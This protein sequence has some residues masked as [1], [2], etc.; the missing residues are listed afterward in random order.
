VESAY[1]LQRMETFD[2]IALLATNLRANLDEAFTRRLDVVIDFPLPDASLRR[3]LW[4]RCL[5]SIAPRATDI[6]FDFLASAFELAGGHIRSCAITAAYLAAQAGRPVSMLDLVGAVAR[7][8]RKLGRLTLD[9]EFGHYL[10]LM[11]TASG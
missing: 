9:V 3:R 7:E 2:G 11:Q 8:Y 1:L 10:P 4:D 6:D 5:G